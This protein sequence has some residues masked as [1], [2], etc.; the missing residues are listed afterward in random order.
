MGEGGLEFS[1]V[2]LKKNVRHCLVPISSVYSVDLPYNS[3]KTKDLF[4]D[5]CKTTFN[6]SSKDEVKNIAFLVNWSLNNLIRYVRWR[7]K[8]KPTGHKALKI[9]F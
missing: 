6:S 5:H 1:Y 3:F 2:T 4:T 7:P 8:Y 9:G